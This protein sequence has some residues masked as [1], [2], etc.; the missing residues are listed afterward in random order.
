MYDGSSSCFCD[1]EGGILIIEQ[2]HN[3]IITVFGNSTEIT[4]A[5]EGILWHAN[6]HQWLDPNLT[7]SVYPNEYPSSG[8]RAERTHELLNDAYG[9]ITLETCKTIARDHGGG[10]D[11]NGKDSGDICR[12]PDNASSKITAFSWI[13]MPKDLT[14][15]W[16]HTS[17]CKGIFF[18]HD[19]SKIFE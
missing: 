15:F 13:I 10:F 7:G 6:H 8:L 2:T 5:S 19:F 17:P 9:N 3:Y 14:V 4:G 18:K 1:R 16:T 11:M 12:H